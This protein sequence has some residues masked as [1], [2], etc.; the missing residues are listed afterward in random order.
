MLLQMGPL[1]QCA[2]I[3]LVPSTFVRGGLAVPYFPG[4]FFKKTSFKMADGPS[5]TL[6]ESISHID[7]GLN[8]QRKG[9][10]ISAIS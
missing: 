2:V 1:L 3:T 8:L 6:K 9:C 5:K 4:L 7:Q 10:S